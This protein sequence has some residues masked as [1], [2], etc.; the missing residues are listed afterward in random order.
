MVDQYVSALASNQNLFAAH[1]DSFSHTL[2]SGLY[3]PC[4]DLLKTE[5]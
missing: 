3:S 2:G 5:A 1:N 4:E